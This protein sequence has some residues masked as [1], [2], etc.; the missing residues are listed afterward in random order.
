MSWPPDLYNKGRVALVMTIPPKGAMIEVDL[1]LPFVLVVA[2][3]LRLS[4]GEPSLLEHRSNELIRI[5]FISR[6][7]ILR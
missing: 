4:Q 2:L 5:S 7:E 3:R 1:P 6:K